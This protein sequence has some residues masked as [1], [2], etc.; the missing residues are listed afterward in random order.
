MSERRLKIYTP[1]QHFDNKK[2]VSELIILFGLMNNESI[3]S[4]IKPQE[5]NTRNQHR[6]TNVKGYCDKVIDYVN[7][8]DDCDIVVY[9]KKF[10][11]DKLF[12]CM[13]N[14][15][16]VHNKKLFAFYNDD[17]DKK[18][19][20]YSTVCTLYRTSFYK[21]NKLQNEFA[22]PAFVNDYFE[23]N[24]ITNFDE[25]SVGY[26]GHLNNGRREILN[27]LRKSKLIQTNFIIRNGFQAPGIDPLISKKEFMQNISDNLFTF[28]YR[29]AGNFSYRFYETLMMGRIPLLLDTDCVFPF[30]NLFNIHDHCVY[31]IDRDNLIESLIDFCKNR[32]LVKVQKNNRELWVSMF[33]CVGFINT[34]ITVNT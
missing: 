21:K 7:R 1:I 34:F 29:G 20:E 3:E 11:N 14:I 31:V 5:L 27:E 4:S 26:C 17:N 24:I 12:N 22:I 30:E 23:N 16:T 32:D 15:C 6:F 33:S 13:L 2:P 28:C 25:I 9:P 19:I 18:L 10:T 8:I